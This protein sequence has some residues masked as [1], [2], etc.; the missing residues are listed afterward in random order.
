MLLGRGLRRRRPARG[1]GVS[2]WVVGW[3]GNGEGDGEGRR[4]HAKFVGHDGLNKPV[5]R[6]EDIGLGG[7]GLGQLEEEAGGLGQALRREEDGVLELNWESTEGA[8][9]E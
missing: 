7:D 9:L 5:S 8:S 4:T 3:G 2:G 1:L 6:E